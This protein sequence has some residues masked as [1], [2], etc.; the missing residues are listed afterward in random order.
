M[1]VPRPLQLTQSAHHL[2]QKCNQ[3]I[4]PQLLT[5]YQRTNQMTSPYQ[6]LAARVCNKFPCKHNNDAQDVKIQ[7][8]FGHNPLCVNKSWLESPE[9]NA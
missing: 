3:T 6:I 5:E 9:N 7:F 4:K 8:L 1:I 2:D